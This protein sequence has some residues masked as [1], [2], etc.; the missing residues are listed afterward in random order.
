MKNRAKAL[1]I[2]TS[3]WSYKHWKELFYPKDI[4]ANQF[5][6][7]YANYFCCVELN[8]SFYRLPKIDVV[9][10]WLAR[11]P[12]HFSFCPKMSRWITHVK[13]LHEVEDSLKLFFS[14]FSPLKAKL[15]P[16]LVQLPPNLGFHIERVQEFFALLKNNYQG[17]QFAVEA[18]HPSWFEDEAIALMTRH[19]I[20]RVIAESGKRFPYSQTLTANFIYMRFHGLKDL[21]ATNFSNSYL[22]KT[23]KKIH[24]WLKSN[25]V[26]W[27][28]FNND[29]QAYAINNA[30]TL[31]KYLS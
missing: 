10:D 14:I 20:A 26:V 31:I 30:T 17:Y 6:E 22:Q 24:T 2:G 1:H 5:L 7:Y 21:Y 29:A 19:N 13:K 8:A 15:S 23:A 12:K 11:T 27:A 9:K 16:I 28:F 3:G 4:K 18:R 25:K